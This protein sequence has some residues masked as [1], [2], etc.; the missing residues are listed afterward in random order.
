MKYQ[1]RHK[2]DPD[3][4]VRAAFFP[5]GNAHR[6]KFTN[7]L[8]N[9]SPCPHCDTQL[10]KRGRHRAHTR[11]LGQTVGQDVVRMC[12]CECRR[13]SVAMLDRIRDGSMSLYL[14]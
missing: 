10:K 11:C 2:G 8:V 1:P 14:D 4:R 13:M 6:D 9:M 12:D 3:V 5:N 7:L